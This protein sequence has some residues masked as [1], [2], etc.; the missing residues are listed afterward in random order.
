[1]SAEIID[2]FSA[3][4]TLL[5]RKIKKAFK[6]SDSKS[7]VHHFISWSDFNHRES[8]LCVEILSEFENFLNDIGTEIISFANFIIDKPTVRAQRRMICNFLISFDADQE[9]ED[10]YYFILAQFTNCLIMKRSNGITIREKSAYA[11][12]Q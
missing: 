5:E 7:I 3:Q 1:M 4:E 11:S 6:K 9:K 12:D 2:F 8:M 10:D